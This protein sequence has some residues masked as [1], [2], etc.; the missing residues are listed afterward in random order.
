MGTQLLAFAERGQ[1]LSEARRIELAELLRELTGRLGQQAVE[2]LYGYASWI[3]QGNSSGSWD[4]DTA[5]TQDP[6]HTSAVSQRDHADAANG[7]H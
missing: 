7:G 3:L 1:G 5:N 6:G 2:R 4:P